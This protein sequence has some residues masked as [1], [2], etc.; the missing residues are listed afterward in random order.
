ME[1][2]RTAVITFVV[3]ALLLAWASF[4][5]ISQAPDEYKVGVLLTETDHDR[6][7]AVKEGM[8]QAAQDYGVEIEYSQLPAYPT[9]N[10]QWD[11]MNDQI[12]GG[13]DALIVE[14]VAKDLL[15][16]DTSAIGGKPIVLMD[17]D[18]M[19]EGVYDCVH[20][21]D[22]EIGKLLAGK[23]IEQYGEQLKSMKIGI[24]GG[25]FNR[26]S[27][28][29]RQAGFFE[30]IKEFGEVTT[31][32]I[33]HGRSLES[34]LKKQVKQSQ[35]DV[36][37]CLGSSETEVVIDY[38]LSQG[39]ESEI[40]IYGEGYSEKTVYYLDREVIECLVLPNEFAMGYLAI[41]HAVED[42]QNISLNKEN[43]T[44]ELYSV[45]SDEIYLEENQKIL[46]PHI[47]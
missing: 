21:D 46:F 32:S 17:S 33:G 40:K 45:R 27:M 28:E 26:L 5:M 9:M 43:N 18:V 38:I 20:A 14:P 35:P 37:V 10:D 3:L 16:R 8:N 23:L 47:R 13:A 11:L 42:A 1:N 6:W 29:L 30:E 25:E 22:K 7:F 31:W 34:R 2:R 4:S 44:A 36:I 39:L 41:Q 19:P 15:N 24:V 12:Q